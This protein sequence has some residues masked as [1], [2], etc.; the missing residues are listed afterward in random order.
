[1]KILAALIKRRLLTRVSDWGHCAIYEHDLQR[2]WPLDEKNRRA[3]IADF[4]KEYGFRLVVYRKG[5]CAIFEKELPSA[6]REVLGN[7]R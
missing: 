1:L 4:A 5:V 2:I 6:P 7:H 3:K